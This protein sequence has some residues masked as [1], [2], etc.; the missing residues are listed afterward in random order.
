M[1][2]AIFGG[3]GF[4]GSHLISFFK[5]R[6]DHLFIV[7]RNRAK[8]TN[9]VQYIQWLTEDAKPE[10]QLEACDAFINLAGKSIDSN[11]NEQTKKEILE[12]RLT[13]TNEVIRII[14]NVQQKPK[15]LVNASAIGIYGTSLHKLFTEQS[16]DVGDD[17]LAE[18]VK[19][20]ETC[21]AKAEKYGVRVVYTRF[22]V[23]LD[24]H[25][26]ALPK[27]VLP[28]KLFAGGTVGSG[29]QWLS[30]IHIKD[31]V[32]LISFVI[33]N[34]NASGPI[35]ITAPHPVTMNEFG[36]TLS[37]VIKRPHWLPVPSF[38]LKWLLGEKSMLVLEGQQ[39]LPEKASQL[40]FQ[41]SYPT[42]QEA[43]TD[44]YSHK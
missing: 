34:D 11:W 12:S 1:K 3:S 24:Q 2:I 28:Y 10:E 7:T 18:T 36:H 19:K 20:W 9:S 15:V 14:E 39:V 38:A 44:I 26:G 13:A 22:G 37:K 33:E 31:A 27:M 6:G 5:Q 17:F 35:N 41:F 29:K 30:W 43:L 4:I 40:Q 8:H 42:L 25:E 23:V 32:R 16:F 21:A